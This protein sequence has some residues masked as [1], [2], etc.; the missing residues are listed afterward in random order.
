MPY[1]GEDGVAALLERLA[2]RGGWDRVHEGAALIAL[3]RGRA[4]VTLEP[5]N[6]LE[7][8]GTP[9]RTMSEVAAEAAD[10]AVEVDEALQGSAYQQSAIGYTPWAEVD[11]IDWVPKG[12]YAVM[13]EHLAQTGPLAHAMMKG[14]CAVQANYDFSDE[15]DCAAK[16]QLA[17]RLAPLTTAMFAHSPFVHGAPA[18]FMSYRGHVWTK[19][20]PLRTGMPEAGEQFTFERWVDWL[21]DMPMMF[22]KGS[23]GQWRAAGGRTF[24]S[25]MS[26]RE[27]PTWRDWELHLT[28]VFPEVRVKRTIEVRGADS[29]PMPLAMAFAAL[30]RA[31]FY[32]PRIA[33]VAADLA[34]RFVRHG[35]RDERFNEATRNGLRGVVGGRM[36][37]AWAEDLLD[38]VEAGLDAE[39]RRWIQPLS[40]QVETGESPARALLRAY[41]HRPGPAAV[42]ASSGLDV[43]ASR[44]PLLEA[45]ASGPM[46]Q[47]LKGARAIDRLTVL[48]ESVLP[49]LTGE[50]WLPA[51]RALR[52]LLSQLGPSLDIG[53]SGG[54]PMDNWMRVRNGLMP[55]DQMLDAI[56]AGDAGDEATPLRLQ[57][58]CEAASATLVGATTPVVANRR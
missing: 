3:A 31:L 47:G 44:V 11:A 19:T 43:D 6:Q 45:P 7:L 46:R 51:S 25:W 36:L 57:A 32:S 52:D 9:S 13:R 30:W 50:R 41:R 42:L 22:N 58:A 15:A 26:D 38:G 5:G 33:D 28:S 48:A 21:L 20:D 14:T 12:R 4:T 34:A 53:L 10:F 8:S 40:R 37:A 2:A 23:D 56:A 1:A 18:G 16:V 24:R 39:E 17:T 27:P 35:E 29:V 55:V 49:Q 54:L